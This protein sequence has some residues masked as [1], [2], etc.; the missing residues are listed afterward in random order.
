M[1]L[2]IIGIKFYQIKYYPVNY[3]DLINNFEDTVKQILDYCKLPFEDACI[4]FYK[5]K[6][7][8]KTPSAQQVRQPIYTS[9]LDYW[10]NYDPYLDELKKHINIKI[11]IK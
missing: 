10:K 5:S 1:I 4:E 3:E 9:G 11:N 6:R 2:W 8:V 7:S